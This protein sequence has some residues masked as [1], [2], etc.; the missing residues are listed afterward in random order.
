MLAA[1]SCEHIAQA[2]PLGSG[3][4][5]GPQLHQ[6]RGACSAFSTPACTSAAARSMSG[7]R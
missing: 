1:S 3:P 5:L 2:G 6:K 4:A 7:A